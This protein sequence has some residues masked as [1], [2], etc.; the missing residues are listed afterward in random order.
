MG[1]GVSFI[2]K[3][4]QGSGVACS[5]SSRCGSLLARTP[6]S[7]ILCG[8]QKQHVGR[9]AGDVLEAVALRFQQGC[10]L[11]LALRLCADGA[12]FPITYLPIAYH[13]P[14]ACLMYRMLLST[15]ATCCS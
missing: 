1:V 7:Q 5:L 8:W 3:G 6:F 12:C 11:Q 2:D 15:W 14:L 4:S 10:G 13:V 9:I